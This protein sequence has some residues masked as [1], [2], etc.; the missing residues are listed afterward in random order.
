[1]AVERARADAPEF[2]SFH[3]STLEAFTTSD[4]FDVIVFSEVLYYLNTSA[5]L[6]NVQR[7]EGFLNDAGK[8]IVSLKDDGKS[9]A[10]LKILRTRYRWVDGCLFQVKPVPGWKT[11]PDAERP[12]YLVGVITSPA[13]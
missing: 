1:V 12:A 13:E 5:V 3:C 9:A 6:A 10:V 4:R 2:A 8:L 11:L 7:Y